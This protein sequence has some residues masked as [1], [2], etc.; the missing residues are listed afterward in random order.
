LFE[1]GRRIV[2]RSE[3]VRKAQSMAKV[4]LPEKTEPARA[5]DTPD[6]DQFIRIMAADMF[7]ADGI[8]IIGHQEWSKIFTDTIKQ[9]ED[10]LR[11]QAHSD[12]NL[13]PENLASSTHQGG[14][15]FQN[16]LQRRQ[17]GK[18]SAH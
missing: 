1:Q 13:P 8:K 6:I 3:A 5:P 4:Y 17:K 14:S 2:G 18:T 7:L 10:S 16:S 15:S 12:R 9:F 11:Y